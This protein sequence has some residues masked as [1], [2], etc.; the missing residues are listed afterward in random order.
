VPDPGFTAAGQ[1]VA[2]RVTFSLWPGKRG[3]GGEG[4]ADILEW[5][6]VV[7]SSC[8]F[9]FWRGCLRGLM[10]VEEESLSAGRSPSTS[11]V[12]PSSVS[13]STPSRGSWRR[14]MIKYPTAKMLVRSR[15]TDAESSTVSPV[16]RRMIRSR[17]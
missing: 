3:F 1:G 15:G 12:Y 9:D 11:I 7:K 2:G 10:E 5:R 14:I 6:E 4:M 16:L 8:D 13:R 17:K